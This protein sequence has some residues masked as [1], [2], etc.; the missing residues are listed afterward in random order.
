[1]VARPVGTE[2]VGPAFQRTARKLRL[3]PVHLHVCP[4]QSLGGQS[5]LAGAEEAQ[6]RS[7]VYGQE[8][9]CIGLDGVRQST[10]RLLAIKS[11]GSVGKMRIKVL[12]E[13]LLA[14][15]FVLSGYQATL[16]RAEPTTP[17]YSTDNAPW[18]PNKKRGFRRIQR[19]VNQHAD[20]AALAENRKSL[21]A[22]LRK[23]ADGKSMPKYSAG[24]LRRLIDQYNRS[25]DRKF[26]IEVAKAMGGDFIESI[27][28]RPK[29][30]TQLSFDDWGGFFVMYV[31][32]VIED[33]DDDMM[34]D[35]GADAYSAVFFTKNPVE[36]VAELDGPFYPFADPS[37]VLSIPET[38]SCAG[39]SISNGT[40]LSVYDLRKGLVFDKEIFSGSNSASLGIDKPDGNTYEFTIHTEEDSPSSR[41][42]HCESSEW[43][44][45]VGTTYV[46]R[47]S[48][49]KQSCTLR[50]TGRVV[51]EGCRDI[52][53][54]E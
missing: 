42:H 13:L 5:Q 37:I 48:T 27:D 19:D 9:R 3:W 11:C 26:G 30:H 25:Q 6:E 20:E 32:T 50:K 1:M 24:N 41:R 22:F 21:E 39:S 44:R 45:K 53:N 4:H 31:E 51:E 10:D 52:G 18:T 43:V 46:L 29:G 12:L 35:G 54:C 33:H 34:L 23:L 7:R 16:V 15:T 17:E 14:A 49:A 8:A 40:R 36:Q 2:A 47:C 38:T 28:Q